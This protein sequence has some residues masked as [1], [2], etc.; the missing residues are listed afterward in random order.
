VPRRRGGAATGLLPI[1]SKLPRFLC[2]QARGAAPD[3]RDAAVQEVGR[4]MRVR[5][6][7]DGLVRRLAL[8]LRRFPPPS[9]GPGLVRERRRERVSITISLA[10]HGRVL[11]VTPP[12]CVAME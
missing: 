7:S 10:G 12:E 8:E 1:G 9:T 5:V 4:L 2:S 11:D 6:G 3:G